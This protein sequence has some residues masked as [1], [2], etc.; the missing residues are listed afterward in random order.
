[1]KK[2]YAIILSIV[3]ML[4]LSFNISIKASSSG[5]SV[6]PEKAIEYLKKGNI[7]YY[8]GKSTFPNL[9][10]L[11]RNETST[12]GQH[13]YATI[14]G[15]SDSRVPIEM[16]FDA[17]IGD[18]FVIRVAG[19]VSD[20]DEAGSI[21]YGVDHLGTPVLVVL[22]HSG[23]GAV[24][25]VTKNADVH[26]NI[27]PLIDN[28]IPAVNKAKAIHGKSFSKE[29][30]AEA[31]KLNVWQSIEDLLRKSPVTIKRVQNGSL[32]IIGAV[33]HLDNG[34]VEWLGEHPNQATIIASSGILGIIK[35][36]L[37]SWIILVL[38]I[39]VIGL[40]I[41]KLTI[42]QKR[43]L[44]KIQI[45]GRIM[46]SF[47]AAILIMTLSSIIGSVKASY[48]LNSQIFITIVLFS[49]VPSLIVFIFTIAYTNSVIGSFH[50]VINMLKKK[51]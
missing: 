33:Y 4:V 45:K 13:P 50:R 36:M 3:P 43:T 49:L 35:P 25:A 46:W 10:Q 23:C 18:I 2:M 30:L 26:G 11:R 28:I 44:K 40:V 8:T 34:K 48:F 7:R 6:S 15:C 19:N 38:C 9:N 1:M 31:I 27:P 39:M 21:E 42:S 51:E 32:K 17:G 29:L 41:F 47:A 16:L 12:K 20:I 14:I 37:F 22:G 5:P 24:T